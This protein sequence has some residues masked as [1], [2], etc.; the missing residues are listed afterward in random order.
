MPFIARLVI[1]GNPLEQT[2]TID[3]LSK[4]LR[5]V[6]PMVQEVHTSLG[7]VTMLQLIPK[8]GLEVVIDSNKGTP[9]NLS[10]FLQGQDPRPENLKSGASQRT[11]IQTQKS[12]KA[13]A[14]VDRNVSPHLRNTNTPSKTPTK[15]QSKTPT[16]CK[17]SH[18]TKKA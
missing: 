13:S 1:A 10:E 2:L 8:M 3:D 6:V 7:I 14:K 4:R 11:S 17:D 18:S 9:T 5:Q 15:Y 16:Q 12:S